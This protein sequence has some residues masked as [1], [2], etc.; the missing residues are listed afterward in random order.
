MGDG[1]SPLTRGVKDSP[2]TRVIA[3]QQR[4]YGSP[5]T[6]VPPRVEAPPR[7]GARADTPLRPVTFADPRSLGKA[8]GRGEPVQRRWHAGI[9]KHWDHRRWRNRPILLHR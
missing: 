1:R 5:T 2:A 3:G 4:R 6:T 9:D 7:A 8:E